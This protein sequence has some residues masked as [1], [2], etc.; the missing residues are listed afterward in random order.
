MKVDRLRKKHPWFVYESYDWEIKEKDLVMSFHFLLPARHASQGETGG[1]SDIRFSP[2]LTIKNVDPQKV[3]A[4]H[5]DGSLENFIFHMGLA[6]IPSYWKAAASPIIQIKPCGLSYFQK[7][8]WQKLFIKG[9]GEY[10]YVNNIDFTQP[11]FLSIESRRPHKPHKPHKIYTSSR[12]LIPMGGGKDS[13]VTTE[14]LK[15][16]HPV[17]CMTLNPTPRMLRIINISKTKNP[18]I[19]Q[20]KI[21]P[22][23]LKLNKMGYLN[24]HTPFSSYL[25]FLGVFCAA[26]FDCDFVAVSNERSA[27]EGNVEYRGH[28]VNH[29]Y[30]KS[31]E[32]E[33]DFRLYT[34][35]YLTSSIEYF[36]FLRP[37]Y[38]LQISRVFAQYPKY[39]PYVLSCNRGQKSERWCN[40]CSKCFFVYVTLFPFL[41]KEKLD[42]IFG[43]NLYDK[44]Y[45]L[46]IFEE[47]T[48]KQGHKPFECVGTVKETHAALS[49]AIHNVEAQKGHLPYLLRYAK[50]YISSG[51]GLSDRSTEKILRSFHGKHSIPRKFINTLVI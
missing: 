40:K 48:G 15:N 14:L 18:I 25:A 5:K 17:R 8:W 42:I 20:R 44:K 47:L 39:F 45:F 6:E 32:F 4:L 12:T 37:L 31:F 16:A 34:K 35:R 21:D 41:E 24:G 3:K 49:L 11:K 27:D 1:E 46:P 30:S 9:M 10:F 43:T 7:R 28:V 36:S 29:Q 50:R 33:K 26:L 19:V 13:V 2:R 38:E 23:L 51:D 22:A